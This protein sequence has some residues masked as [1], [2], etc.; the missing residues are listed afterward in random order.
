MIQKKAISLIEAVVNIVKSLPEDRALQMRGLINSLTSFDVTSLV[1]L[2]GKQGHFQPH[3]AVM[4]NI[5]THG[6]PTFPSRLIEEKIANGFGK[7]SEKRNEILGE[8]VY[9]FDESTNTPDLVFDALHLVDPRMQLNQD[10]YNSPLLESSFEKDF[11]FQQLRDENQYLRQLLIPQRLFTS[12][13][14]PNKASN[15]LNQSVD[16]SVELPYLHKIKIVDRFGSQRE[17]QKHTGFIIEIDGPQH[18][19]AIIEDNNR[20]ADAKEAM[21]ETLHVRSSSE[22]ADIDAAMKVLNID[23][24]LIKCKEISKRSLTGVWK[25]ILQIVLSPIAISRLQSMLVDYLLSNTKHLNNNS[26]LKIGIIEQDVPCGIQAISD[27]AELAVNLQNL[28]SD[29]FIFPQIDLEVY[30]SAEFIDS[31]LHKT[32]ENIKV[33]KLEDFPVKNHSYD[34]KELEKCN[35]IRKKKFYQGKETRLSRRIRVLKNKRNYHDYLRWTILPKA[36]QKVAVF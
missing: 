24:Y 30:S 21:W 23:P 13:V 32:I 7:L 20:D 15:Y 8:F 5:I 11:I 25:D 9:L 6:L 16:L 36:L 28:S 2:G 18:N 31:P 22:Q 26:K 4:H 19:Q 29:P 3:L 34:W 14:N 27:L 12:I 10:E 1:E 17:V 33:R 35:K